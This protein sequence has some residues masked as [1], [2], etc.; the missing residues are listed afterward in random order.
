MI[1]ATWARNFPNRR[2]L[3][4]GGMII[5]YM[6]IGIYSILWPWR[7]C[8][9]RY[10]KSMGQSAQPPRWVAVQIRNLYSV[11]SQ[12]F[13]PPKLV[14]AFFFCTSKPEPS[15]LWC[16]HQTFAQPLAPSRSSFAKNFLWD[17]CTANPQACSRRTCQ[18]ISLIRARPSRRLGAF[19][20]PAGNGS[21]M[22]I[23]TLFQIRSRSRSFCQTH[24]I[25]HHTS[26]GQHL[27]DCSGH[28]G[29]IHISGSHSGMMS[30]SPRRPLNIQPPSGRCS[31]RSR[32]FWGAREEMSGI[33]LRSIGSNETL[34]QWN[35]CGELDIPWCTVG[36]IRGDRTN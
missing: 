4:N 33:Y 30:Q 7:I 5:N 10:T 18:S 21:C 16:G 9:W 29:H 32:W 17:T 31:E 19:F 23:L 1:I 24:R 3:S 35:C 15:L 14:T 36:L 12:R 20:A 34:V 2:I 28:S 8:S 22:A 11:D 13:D 6:D 26:S 27:C 25:A